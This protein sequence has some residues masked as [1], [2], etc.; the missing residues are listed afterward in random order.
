MLNERQN[1]PPSQ[2]GPA[3]FQKNFMIINHVITGISE[4]TS[5]CHGP[6]GVIAAMACE[7]SI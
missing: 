7:K 5:G 2:S 6:S 4:T 1:T 3:D